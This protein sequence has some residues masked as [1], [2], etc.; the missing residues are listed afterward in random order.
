MEK[1]NNEIRKNVDDE[2]D[3]DPDIPKVLFRKGNIIFDRYKIVEYLNKG[4]YGKA[5]KAED[6]NDSTPVAVKPIKKS[7]QHK[8]AV[9]EIKVLKFLK[10]VIRENIL[11]Y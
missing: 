9:H 8:Y 3:S 1:E 4:T 11:Y 7:I 10:N 6:I 5:F 2:D